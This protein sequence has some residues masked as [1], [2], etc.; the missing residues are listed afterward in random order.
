MRFSKNIVLRKLPSEND[1]MLDMAL[2]MVRLISKNNLAG[3]PTVMI[4]PVGPTAQ[5]PIFAGIANEIQLDM[6]NTHFFSMDEYMITSSEM[7]SSHDPMSF[8]YRLNEA[9]YNRLDPRIAPPL[10]N[11]NSPLFGQE[12]E[13]DERLLSLG[14]ADLCLGGIG[15]NGHIAFNEPPEKPNSMTVEEFASTPTRTLKISEQTLVANAI[16]YLRGDIH[17]MPKWC[18]TIGMNSILAS[19]SIYIAINRDWQHGIL[20]RILTGSVTPEIPGSLL[21]LHQNVE[22]VAPDAIAEG[23][24]Q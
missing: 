16:G 20:K 13:Y 7:I 17:G 22:I 9:F 23:I 15:I 19:K 8:Q 5:Y 21:Q 18:I 10:S 4:I 11:R 24:K 1:V 2:T 14:G 3:R 6:S 12:A